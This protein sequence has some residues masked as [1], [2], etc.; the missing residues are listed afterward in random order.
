LVVV[1]TQIGIHTNSMS[2]DIPQAFIA[3]SVFSLLLYLALAGALLA[4]IPPAPTPA[5]PH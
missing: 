3:A 2:Q 4:K 5:N 1:I